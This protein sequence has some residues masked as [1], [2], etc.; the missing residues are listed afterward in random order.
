MREGVR[1]KEA[2]VVYQDVDILGLNL[3]ER[4][5]LTEKCRRFATERHSSKC[6][7]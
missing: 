3:G 5:K 6:E 4:N 7:R 2:M 1:E